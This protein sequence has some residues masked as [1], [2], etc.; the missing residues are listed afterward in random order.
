ME[1]NGMIIGMAVSVIQERALILIIIRKAKDVFR[2]HTSNAILDSTYQALILMGLVKFAILNPQTA[3][4]EL[5]HSALKNQE[6]SIALYVKT[7][8]S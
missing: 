1:H 2:F 3:K 4:K 6:L 8:F 7:D 5:A